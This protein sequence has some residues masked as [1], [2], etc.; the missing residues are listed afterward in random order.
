MGALGLSG[1][2]TA[3]EEGEVIGNV[4][5]KSLS[6]ERTFS[7]ESDP[8]QLRTRL[9]ELC[10]SVSE[11]MASHV[12]PL[13]G[14]C[15]GLK[16]KTSAFE[17]KSREKRCQRFIGFDAEFGRK[18]PDT[19]KLRQLGPGVALNPGSFQ[20]AGTSNEGT[21]SKPVGGL[22]ANSAGDAVDKDALGDDVAGD[23]EVARVAA[24]LYAIAGDMLQEFLPCELRLMGVRVSSFRGAQAALQKG[25]QQL[26]RFFR[27]AVCQNSLCAIGRQW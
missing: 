2:E 24:E 8:E 23:V 26:G 14:K 19:D 7:S 11:E 15:I 13:A 10:R 1:G 3:E 18:R 9:Q 21:P 20:I 5:R 27:E 4:S 16:L 6:N 25:Q 12:P 22:G 17:V